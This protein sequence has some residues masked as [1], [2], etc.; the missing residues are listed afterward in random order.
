ML[1]LKNQLVADGA[2]PM[3]E[4]EICEKVLGQDLDMLK[5]LVLALNPSH[6][7]NLD[8]YLLSVR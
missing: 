7:L 1:E 2:I 5:V 6:F 8:V 3:T 4:A